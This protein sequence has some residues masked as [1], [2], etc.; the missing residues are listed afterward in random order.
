MT[1]CAGPFG[2]PLGA[3]PGAQAPASGLAT[4]NRPQ[5]SQPQTAPPMF[6]P[7]RPSQ[8]P[9]SSAPPHGP[10]SNFSY[11]QGPPQGSPPGQFP[12]TIPQLPGEGPRPATTTSDF[13]YGNQH[14]GQNV[15]QRPPQYM[16][17]L[18]QVAP[19]MQHLQGMSL[20]QANQSP[21]SGPPGFRAPAQPAG[22]PPF[23]APPTWQTPQRRVYPDAY[24]GSQP[25]NVSVGPQSHGSVGKM[26]LLLFML[27]G[28]VCLP[29]FWYLSM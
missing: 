21:S 17:G 29:P 23:M 20:G 5:F 3:T 2:T 22:G 25:P 9:P 12:G 7:A 10:P 27:E 13:L 15:N 11:Q 6:Q 16:Q 19:V 4:G 28:S 1:T 24:P 26:F 18:P 14:L 8:G